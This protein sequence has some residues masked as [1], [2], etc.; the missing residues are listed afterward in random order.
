MKPNWYKFTKNHCHHGHNEFFTH[1]AQFQGKCH[2][3]E[4]ANNVD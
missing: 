3:H 1:N 4:N 2:G